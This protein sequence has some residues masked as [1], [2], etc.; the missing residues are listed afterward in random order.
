VAVGCTLAPGP[1]PDAAAVRR[2][3]GQRLREALAQLPERRRAAIVLFVV[4]GY[5]HAEIGRA[6]GI[7]QGTAR[8]DV[9]YA[10]RALRGLL[11]DWKET[12]V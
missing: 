12:P 9:F 1:Q 3:L 7:P 2:A 11:A 4:E 10:R 5:S 6:L 8:S